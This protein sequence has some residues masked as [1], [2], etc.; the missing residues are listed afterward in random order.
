MPLIVKL[1]S[2][3]CNA[4]T[5]TKREKEL[6]KPLTNITSIELIVVLSECYYIRT[7]LIKNHEEKVPSEGIETKNGN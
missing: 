2:F 5:I 1:E 3:E 7:M 4:S 6:S